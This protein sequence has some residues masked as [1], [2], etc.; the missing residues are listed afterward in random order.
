ML[1]ET[2]LS[3][4][5]GPAIL[6]WLVISVFLRRR[7]QSG[8]DP[9]KRAWTEFRLSI[10]ATGSI[11]ILLWFALP[12]TPSLSTF[13]YPTDLA[14]VSQPKRLLSLLQDYNRALVRTTEV[15]HW[16]IFVMVWW[17]ISSVYAFSKVLASPPRRR[18][19]AQ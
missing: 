5:L 9:I 14:I 11:L 2:D 17:F 6:V 19:P 1:I 13:G 10:I 8:T 15:L 18:D 4:I 3:Y 7:P 16:V 12:S